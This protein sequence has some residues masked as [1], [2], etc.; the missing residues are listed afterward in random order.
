M[1][2]ANELLKALIEARLVYPSGVP[3]V[4]GRGG[5]FEDVVEGVLAATDKAGGAPGIERF[6]FPP[7]M[8]R[9]QFEASGYLK[10]FPNLAGTVHAFCGNDADHM[11]L[12]DQLAKGEDWTTGQRA[13]A[14][15][16][17]PASCY[18]VYPLIAARG[19]LPEAG[20][21]VS[22][23]GYCFRNEPSDDPT[24]VQFFR[25]REYVRIG[26]PAQV[27]EFRDFWHR[28]ALEVA[29]WLAL[30]AELVIANDPFFGRAGRLSVS[31]QRGQEL[32][33]EIVIPVSSDERPTACM[34]VNYHQDYFANA[35]GIA[36]AD[37]S[38]AHSACVGFGLERITLALF[39]HHGVDTKAW[40]DHVKAALWE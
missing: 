22:L 10:N 39:R 36:T 12:L 14:V 21:L 34:S 28:R 17:T 27:M 19:P 37:G 6:H 33:H 20:V 38:P 7:G 18:P 2:P 30:P 31:V 15:V 11:S 29:K 9:K 5:V 40:P 23:G 4:M 13:G 32:K 24:R 1:I 8:N 25:Q 26:T 3:G 16:L 35:N